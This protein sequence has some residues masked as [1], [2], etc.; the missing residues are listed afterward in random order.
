MPRDIYTDDAKLVPYW[1]EAAPRPNIAEA[2]LPA[3]VDVAVIGAG[4]SGLSAALTIARGGRS[5]VVLEADRP[6]E[7]ASS[8]NGGAV[9]ATLR[10]SFAELAEA[11]GLDAAKTFYGEVRAGRQWLADFIEAEEIDCDFRRVGRFIGCHRGN[12]YERLARDLEMQAKYLGTEGEMVAP[13]DVDRFID[14]KAYRGGRFLAEDGNLH[15]GKL[16]QGLLD[17][18]L[19]EG[20]PVLGGI[21]VTGIARE[22]KGFAVAAGARKIAAR[23]VVIATNGYT[24]AESPWLRKRILPIQSQIIATEPLPLP[25]MER[26]VP[27]NRQL[28]DTCRLHY[29][30]RASPDYTRILFG[31]RAGAA[32]SDD[33]KKTGRMLYKRMTEVY[34]ELDG[35]RLTHSWGGFIAY[36]FDHMLHM[37]E[38]DG[39]FYAAGYCGSGVVNANYFGHKT[40]LKVLGDAAGRT[41][42]DGE[43][44]TQ[45][46]YSGTPWF[47][48]PVIWFKNLQDRFKL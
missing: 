23:Q 41:A 2:A 3:S 31:G 6:G 40:G 38:D 28:G 36:T 19:A 39:L 8:R 5:V 17:K 13:E 43:H 26:L 46:L 16:H 15:P 24:G 12:D 11:E 34:P 18:V 14:T 37:A 33:M 1:W 29:Y 44:P 21:R 7:G 22:T 27:Q 48:A 20:V 9:G 45:A 47:L 35:V 25:T 42:F 30:F 32:E 4:Y 10:H